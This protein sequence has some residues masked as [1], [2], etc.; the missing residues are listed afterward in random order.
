MKR[1]LKDLYKPS[2]KQPALVEVPEM[3]FFMVDGAGDPNTSQEFQDAIQALYGLSFTLKLAMKRKGGQPDYG[4]MPLEGLWWCGEMEAFSMEARDKWRW[5]LMIAQPP[6]VTEA[7][8]QEILA[9][10]RRKHDSPALGKARFEGFH[11]GL[12]AQIMHLG[13]YCDEGPTIEKL[14]AFIKESGYGR[15]GRHHEIY[16]SDPRRSAPEKMKTVLRQPVK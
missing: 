7:I 9:E 4:V 13:P 16:L 11:E 1:V 3:G 8:F 12:S 5:T 15:R 2:A 6:H 14:H 10:V